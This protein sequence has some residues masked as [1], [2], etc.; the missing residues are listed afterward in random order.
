MRCDAGAYVKHVNH[1]TMEWK[2]TLSSYP[3][4][5]GRRAAS[6]CCTSMRVDAVTCAVDID[7]CRTPLHVQSTP[8]QLW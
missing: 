3:D 2:P 1:M 4:M 7:Y 5:T 8:A 6:R